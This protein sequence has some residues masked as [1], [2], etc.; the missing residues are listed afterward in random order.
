MSSRQTGKR[1]P[2]FNLLQMLGMLF[3]ICGHYGSNALSWGGLMR[4]D[5][6]HIA[7]FLFIS[8][9]F[10]NEEFHSSAKKL[11]L[12]IRKRTKKLMVPYYLWNAVYYVVAIVLYRVADLDLGNIGDSTW[13]RFIIEPFRMAKGWGYNVAAW[14]L[15]TLFLIQVHHGLLSWIICHTRRNRIITCAWYLILSAMGVWLRQNLMTDPGSAQIML[16]RVMFLSVWYYLGFLYKTDLEK[17]DQGVSSALV[18]S[19]CLLGKAILIK[20]NGAS[21]F[22][23]YNANYTMPYWDTM[24]RC[25]LSIWFWLRI[26]QILTPAIPGKTAEYFATH[27]FSLMMH[28]GL[29]GLGLNYIMIHIPFIRRSMSAEA[30]ASFRTDIWRNIGPPEFNIIYPIL[31]P[32]IIMTGCFVYETSLDH[33]KKS[34]L[35]RKTPETDNN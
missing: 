9:C 8:G 10:Y 22:V 4:Y 23:F 1:N 13:Q 34:R 21:T 35:R 19:V 18:M 15:P 24:L 11:G 26:A 6:F 33:I 31:I 32:L 16:L 28:Q 30:R 12:F 27:N 17:L 25:F 7:L 20:I 3:V 29:V 2:S 5:D 14:F